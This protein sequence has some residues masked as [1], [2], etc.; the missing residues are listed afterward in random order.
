MP[1]FGK[2]LAGAMAAACLMLLGTPAV[3]QDRALT[4]DDVLSMQTIGGGSLSPDGRWAVYERRGAYD[5]APR[6]DRGGRSWWSATTL[7]LVE[8]EG[9]EPRPLLA[10][11]P[12]PDGGVV[13][14]SWSPDG[15]R[16][17][18]Y[19][20]KGEGLEAGIVSLPGGSV[21]WTGMTPD[22]PTTGAS[23]EWVDAH[24]L[25]LT[26]RLDAS[27]PWTLR[28][29]G[30]GA[31]VMNRRWATAA[32]G[33]V[34]SRT[35]FD[36]EDGAA[37][38]DDTAS[39]L[40]LVLVNVET[41]ATRTLADG[42]IR[43]LS[44][45]PDG[46]WAAVLKSGAVTPQPDAERNVQSA[47][48]NRGL[49]S[50]VPLDGGRIVSLGDG[51]DV[52]PHLLRWSPASS[53]V[54]VWGRRTDQT[55]SQGGLM[56]VGV[57][58]RRRAVD[59]GGLSPL[60]EGRTIDEL[61][62]VRADW[63]GTDMLIFARPPGG[64]RF[65]WWR[66]GEG[67]PVNLTRELQRP[68]ERL[69]AIAGAS[70]LLFADGGLWR[71][72]A[73]GLVRMP[74]SFSD[75]IQGEADDPMKPI[76]LRATAP[77][78]DWTTGVRA[79][80][81]AV[82]S[83]VPGRGWIGTSACPQSERLLASSAAALLS[84]CVDGGVETLSLAT[85]RGSRRI[86]AVNAGFAGT[87]ISPAVTIPHLDFKGRPARS[88]L[89]LPVGVTAAGVKGLIVQIYPGSAD[90]GRR[91]DA[92]SLQS[93]LRAQLLTVGG[94]AVLSVG[95]PS[96]TE[97]SRASMF[98]D[99]STGVELA[100][101]A[102]L[103]ARPDLPHDRLALVGH[104]FG[105]YATLGVATRSRRFRS[106]VVWA[107]ATDMF[108]KW[109]EFMAHGRTWPGDWFTLNQPIGAVETGQAGL[110]APPWWAITAYAEAS[111]YLLADRITTPA[112]LIT[113][114][115]DYVPMTQAE[116]MFTALHR[117][118]RRARLITYWGE[119]HDNSSPANIRDVYQQ[120]FDWLDQTV[121]EAEVT[122]PPPAEPP[123]P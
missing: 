120:I 42:A 111:P 1:W 51:L 87:Q 74:D 101:N 117:Q 91:V 2:P 43:D 33:R 47:V 85:L 88:Y 106:L 113:A 75:W 24:H 110:G 115:R 55:W 50:L 64:G 9:G 59:A 41:G 95:L 6:F 82:R 58:G 21:R 29:D 11:D 8:V 7:M 48:L 34:P 38:S 94:Y 10:P 61:R 97:S 70:A 4:L 20:L 35:V 62:P 89:Y 16:L 65:D 3:A 122:I 105:G 78:R 27:L 22:L 84:L 14:G 30:S 83:P 107:G 25:L 116:R 18:V 54:L 37:S 53:E 28:F 39:P 99:F 109:G 44:L 60:E 19:R 118:G 45:S 90:D 103:A 69:A 66:L 63:I 76:R 32:A 79:G 46:R 15:E 98:D 17:L 40:R 108:G 68:P 12:D 67:D 31:E 52:A 80:G 96:Q 36:T 5:S 81:M 114:D 77:R 56:A 13:L 119:G 121:G 86:D 49:L 71:L 100:V 92:T 104:S 72:D 23:S 93:S 57:D 123:R 112:L 73:S 102:V 26:V